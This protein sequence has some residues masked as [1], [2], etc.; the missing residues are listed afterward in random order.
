[1]KFKNTKRSEIRKQKGRN[2]TIQRTKAERQ[3][4]RQ[5]QQDTSKVGTRTEQKKLGNRGRKM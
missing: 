5:E 4:A 2:E 3:T 1:M